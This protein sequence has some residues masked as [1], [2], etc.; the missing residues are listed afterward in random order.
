[1]D[2]PNPEPARAAI[3]EIFLRKITSGK[4]LD[5]I[6]DRTGCEPSPTPYALFEFCR[7]LAAHAPQLDEFLLI[8]MGGATTDVYSYHE[9][10]PVPGVVRRGLPEPTIK[11]TVEG[12][13]GMRVSAVSAVEALSEV[14]MFREANTAALL[15]YAEE[16]KSSPE[17]LAVTPQ[18]RRFD[19]ML[20]G[21]NIATSIMRHAGRA[22]EVATADG[23]VT[24]QAGRDLSSVKTIIG[25]G[26]YLSHSPDFDPRDHL[27]RIG[28]DKFGKR[29]LVSRSE[30]Y[31][32]DPANLLPLLANV[33]RRHPAA[34]ANAAARLLAGLPIET[35]PQL[36]AEAR[37]AI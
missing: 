5:R 12:D 33:S 35:N 14:T 10:L 7:S 26:G 19:A 17:H 28:T 13:L 37:C 29:I 16:L 8:D 25:T 24:V 18:E 9:D 11:R 4:G 1:L 30:V 2:T 32:R 15:N 23:M 27:S 36:L 3:R 21:A 6:I 22:H 20:A 34:A 31:L